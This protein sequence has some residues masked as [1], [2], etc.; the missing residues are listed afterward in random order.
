[1]KKKLVI[2]GVCIILAAL[3]I[4]GCIYLFRSEETSAEASPVMV[5][6]ISDL[7]GISSSAQGLQNRYAGVVEPQKTLEIQLENGRMV[8][9]IYVQEGQEVSEGDPLFQYD[10]DQEK[11]SL[12]QQKLELER[13]DNS[14][15]SQKQ[16]IAEL[17]EEKKK[18]SSEMQLQYT[19]EIQDS[20]A[21]LK[22]SEYE[23]KLKAM[24][25]EKTQKSIESS[26]VTSTMGGVV[27]AINENA[28]SGEMYDSYGN[29]TSFMTIL[30]TGE[31]RVKG[32]INEQN[33]YQIYEEMPVL[34]RSRVQEDMVW[35]GRIVEIDMENPDKGN[36]NG[37][38][39]GGYVDESVQSSK[40]PFYIV[41]DSYEGLMLGQHVY[42]EMAT[43]G[44]QHTEGVWLY[45]G[46]LMADEEGNWS[47]WTAEKGKIQKRTVEIGQY[48]E[49]MGQYEI[50]SGLSQEDAVAWP[51]EGIEAGAPVFGN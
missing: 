43:E 32:T 30:A 14:I 8:S 12:E 26:I 28:G 49:M 36:N 9:E 25:I 2:I 40:Y 46:Y 37:M 1:M 10:T 20:T 29:E 11:L 35:T 34:V 15:E 3:L 17:E 47:V 7:M 23:R 45:E 27:R 50:I 16:K 51:E 18:A 44:A 42:I 33:M 41:L 4:A 24:E 21:A 13:L 22:Q 6:Q 48:D 38:Y 19:M 5:T 31:Y 39:Y